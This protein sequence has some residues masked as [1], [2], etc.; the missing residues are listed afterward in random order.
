ML[1][2]YMYMYGIS[3]SVL[4]RAKDMAWYVLV[5]QG[6]NSCEKPHSERQIISIKPS[7]RV[8]YIDSK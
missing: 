4:S 5:I 8:K 7:A 2:T 6:S 1:I 3:N